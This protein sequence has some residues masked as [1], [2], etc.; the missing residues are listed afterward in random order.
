MTS[1][2]ERTG[3]AGRLFMALSLSAT[4]LLANASQALVIDPDED[5]M[6]SAF[7][8]GTNLVRGYAGDNRPTLRTSTDG[9]FGL[10]G[11]ETI[12]IDFASYDFSS[13]SGPY[14]ATLTLESISGGFGADAGPGN[15]FTVS[16][17]GVAANPFTTIADDTNPGGTLSWLTFY[18]TLIQPADPAAQ[19]AIAG[20][21][22]VTIDVTAIVN[23]WIAGV[24]TNEQLA[25]TGLEDLSGSD[26]L[27]GFKNNT[28]APGST[29]LTLTA[30]PEPGTATLMLL[31]LG[32]LGS[33]KRAREVRS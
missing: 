17:H 32:L 28:E 20:F 29:Y 11:A 13:L 9:A 19:T 8:T 21:G 33:R 30:V 31:G 5:V 18:Q 24:N 3:L 12:Y 2:L 6:T 27:H 25:L 15:P 7:F 16:A 26:F 10:A 1:I 22:T 23:A 14:T 4:L